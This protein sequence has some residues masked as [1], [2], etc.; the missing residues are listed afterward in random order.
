[1]RLNTCVSVTATLFGT[2][3][4]RLINEISRCRN[5]TLPIQHSMR[6]IKAL[7]AKATTFFK[8]AH[9][10][11]EKHLIFRC[12]LSIS[13]STCVCR[14]TC[15]EIARFA[16]TSIYATFEHLQDFCWTFLGSVQTSGFLKLPERG[17]IFSAWHKWN[18]ECLVWSA[19]NVFDLIG[20]VTWDWSTANDLQ[21]CKYATDFDTI[22]PGPEQL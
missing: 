20:A 21:I 11:Y 5:F 13:A 15:P 9:F 18:V 10:W 19:W 17:R 6:Q 3:L 7:H 8:S 16:R 14:W 2:L 12:V 1:M 22:L 4:L